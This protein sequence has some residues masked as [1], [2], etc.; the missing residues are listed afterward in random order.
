MKHFDTLLFLLHA[1]N[2]TIDMRFVAAEQVPQ[3][4]ALACYRA[5]KKTHLPLPERWAATNPSA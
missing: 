5:K 1:V 3:F 4:A 2:H